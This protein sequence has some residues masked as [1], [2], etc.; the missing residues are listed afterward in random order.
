MAIT[1]WNVFLQQQSFSD[2]TRNEF[3]DGDNKLRW[4]WHS[5]ILGKYARIPTALGVLYPN[6]QAQK[7][8]DDHYRLNWRHHGLLITKFQSKWRSP[9]WLA[10]QALLKVGQ[11]YNSCISC[12][13]P[14]STEALNLESTR[15]SNRM[16]RSWKYSY[17]LVPYLFE[18]Q[19]R[20]ERMMK[21]ST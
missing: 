4:L 14:P 17:E 20:N 19:K 9:W 7:H 2:T 3:L 21:V 5:W 1:R 13:P 10:S 16:P 15:T 6:V 8:H 18:K 12:L 11:C